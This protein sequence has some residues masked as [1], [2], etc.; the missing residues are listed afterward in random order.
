MGNP[1]GDPLVLMEVIAEDL[2]LDGLGRAAAHEGLAHV[3]PLD[4]HV[5]H[6]GHDLPQ[7][8]QD[9]RLADAALVEADEEL[10]FVNAG[11]VH[12]GDGR[13]DIILVDADVHTDTLDALD[14][15]DD[16]LHPGDGPIRDLEQ[17]ADGEADLA[18][19]QGLVTAGHEVG[20]EGVSAREAGTSSNT[21]RL[22]QR[23][24]SA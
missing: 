8:G 4:G 19:D 9:L 20:T 10:G 14:V 17:G 16:A 21:T 22:F 5:V 23:L 12:A 2:H 1:L 24:A 18:H 3:H 15:L 7:R 6:R 13:P 11:R